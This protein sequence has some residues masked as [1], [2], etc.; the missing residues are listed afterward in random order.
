MP[1]EVALG[2][3]ISTTKVI[4]DGIGVNWET[5]V[6]SKILSHFI[7]RKIS[8][9]PMETILM[10][11]RELKHL[12]SLVKLARRKKDSKA[13]DN[14]VSM[15]STF[16]TFMNI[17]INKT[18]QSKTFHLF[19]EINNYVVEGLVDIGA[20]MSVMVV[21]VVGEL[22]IMDFVTRS[23]TYKITPRVVT[24]AMGRINKVHV[25]VGGVQCTMTFMVVDMNN[26][27][28]LLRLNFLIKIGAILD[29]E[30][31]LIQVRHGPRANVEV[32]P[33]TMV[34]L[35]QRMNSEALMW[36]ITVILENTHISGDFDIIIKFLYQNSPIMPKG[37]MR[38]LH[39]QT[40]ILIIVN[41]V[42]KGITK[43]SRLMM[44]MSLKV[45]SLK[46][47]YYQKDHN[48]FYN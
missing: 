4:G 21:T 40:L 24:Q 25:K 22:G 2:G 38:L 7:K 10:I 43:L 19:V 20:S 23:E 44:R 13:M 18:H 15:F 1:V 30:Q 11:L 47:R 14:Q 16:P 41:I 29:V 46:I 36:D 6:R 8:L 17:C 3:A 31:G 35:L 26:Y 28:V 9:S 45:L 33:L 39:I 34:N 32:L 37:S 27:D 48:R 12:E 5:S 42:M